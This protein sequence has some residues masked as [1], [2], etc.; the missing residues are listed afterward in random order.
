[1]THT[2]E[3]LR[4]EFVEMPGLRLTVKQVQR[5]CG[6][7]GTTCQEVLNALVDLKFLRVNADGTYARLVDG[8][9]PRSARA[10]LSSRAHVKRAS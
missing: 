2:M 7:D 9:H 10:D 4:A 8:H 1:M 3:R 5:L 6:V